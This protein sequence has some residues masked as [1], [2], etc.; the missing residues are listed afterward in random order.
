MEERA[1][2]IEVSG[3]NVEDAIAQALNKLGLERDQVDIEVIR[4]GGRSLLG[5]LRE[6][7]VDSCEDA[8]NYVAF[9]PDF[10]LSLS[11][12]IPKLSDYSVF[13]FN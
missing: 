1:N 7:A 4:E 5:L 2:S 11:N 13:L 3:R 12:F 9:F 8:V 10:G 6:D